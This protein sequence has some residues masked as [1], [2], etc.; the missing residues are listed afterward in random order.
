MQPREKTHCTCLIIAFI[1]RWRSMYHVLMDQDPS[2]AK[3][4]HIGY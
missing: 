1:S 4:N 2:A 3:Y